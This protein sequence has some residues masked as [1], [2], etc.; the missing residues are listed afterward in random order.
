M[1]DMGKGG[2]WGVGGGGGE[3]SENFLGKFREISGKFWEISGKFPG[4]LK[5]EK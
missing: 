5:R 3:I 4:F 2:R 1:W